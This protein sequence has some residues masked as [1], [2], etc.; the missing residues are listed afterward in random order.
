MTHAVID[1]LV[2]TAPDLQAGSR[3][4][5][6]LLGVTPT[7]GG[8]HPRMGTH[9]LLM[10]LGPDTYLEV[11]AIDPQGQ[12]PAQPR[13]F[14]LDAPPAP[15][16]RFATW[17]MR[18]NDIEQAIRTSPLEHGTVQPMSRGALNWHISIPDDGRLSG[19]GTVPSLIQWE[20]PPYPASRLAE[21]HCTL[22]ELQIHHPE[23]AALMQCLKALQFDGPVTLHAS[24]PA[25]EPR[26]LALIATPNGMR[27]LDSRLAWSGNAT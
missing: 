23:P 3:W 8:S 5:Q 25:D 12:A 16:S 10:K 21:S 17:V 4:I 27:T 18:V 2:I 26:L 13:W 11:I 7:A 1:H 15:G 14:Q 9:N 20:S 24:Q 22:T 6:S 19:N